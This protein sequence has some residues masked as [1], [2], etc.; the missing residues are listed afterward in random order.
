MQNHKTIKYVEILLNI[1][2]AIDLC[3]GFSFIYL[4]RHWFL[5]IYA[6]AKLLRR[7]MR[8]YLG[9]NV[10]SGTLVY[11]SRFGVFGPKK[12]GNPGIT[13]RVTRCVCERIAQNVAQAVF[14]QNENITCT[15][16]ISSPIIRAICIKNYHPIGEN[17]PNLG[18]MLWSQFSAIFDNFRRKNCRFSQKPMLW[19]KVC[20]F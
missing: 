16:E 10:V 18:S 13:N 5:G 17:S 3:C 20:I 7:Q 8:M 14:A 15:A 6:F 12:S 4:W 11:F 2:L 1:Q 19:S 9:I